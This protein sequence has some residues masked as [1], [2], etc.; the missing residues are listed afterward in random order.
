MRVLSRRLNEGLVIDGK[1]TLRVLEVRGDRIRLAIEAAEGVRL[2]R[3]ETLLS[4]PGVSNDL[5]Q[6]AT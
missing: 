1:T 2:E 6:P 3:E 5:A 4:R